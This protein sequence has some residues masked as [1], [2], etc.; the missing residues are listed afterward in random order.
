MSSSGHPGRRR[1]RLNPWRSRPTGASSPSSRG[2]TNLVPGDTN[3]AAGRLRPRPADGHDRAGEPR[4]GRRPGR[5]RQLRPVDL[6]ERALRR[7]R[8][9]ATNLVPGDTNGFDDV[10]VR[11]RRPGTTERVER[12]ARAAPRAMATAPTPRSR[13]TGASSP[14]VSYA[15]NLVPGDTNGTIDVFVRDRQ[16][17]TTE[18]VSVGPQRQ[19]GQRRQL[20]ASAGDHGGRALRRLR[21]RAP[22]TS[23]RATPTAPTTSSSATARGRARPG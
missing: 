13:L 10:F 22:P 16:A 20:H 11:D 3:G 7:L 12:L 9:D 18:R 2:A 15:T 19:A 14:S 4:V 17:G 1:Q 23:S 6:G 8:V 5:R 21:A